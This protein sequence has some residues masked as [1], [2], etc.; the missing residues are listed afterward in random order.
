MSMFDTFKKISGSFEKKG[1]KNSPRSQ[2]SGVMEGE[3][4][5][6]SIYK[7]MDKSRREDSDFMKF[8]GG[9]TRQKP[10]GKERTPEKTKAIPVPK[11]ISIRDL[12]DLPHLV[13]EGGLKCAFLC[14]EKR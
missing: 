8:I 5:I 13:D 7:V 11:S 9:L 3:R 2:N 14:R 6:H 12:A 10:V 4:A 1:A